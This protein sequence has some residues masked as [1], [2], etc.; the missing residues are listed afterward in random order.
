MYKVDLEGNPSIFWKNETG[1]SSGANG[2]DFHPDGY[3]LVSI[4][5][6]NDKGL[7][8]DYGLVKIPVNDPAS[9]K[10]VSVSDGFTG[11]DGMVLKENGNIIGVTN[12]GTSPGGNTLIELSSNDD[13]KSAKVINS[14]TIPASTTVAV[15]PDNK[16]FVINQD[17]TKPM[18]EE[19][20]IERIEF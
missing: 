12:N 4:L 6:V 13:W 17:F 20:I 1:I 8:A 9:A 18:K 10:L 15:T 7:Y 14:K 2:L 5:S 3:L 11:F 16:I 19:W